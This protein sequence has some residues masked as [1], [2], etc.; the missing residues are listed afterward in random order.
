MKRFK[1]LVLGFWKWTKA[2]AMPFL[3]GCFAT[4][5]ATIGFI[6]GKRSE[7][8]DGKTQGKENLGFSFEKIEEE[9]DR[10]YERK[11]NLIN[12]RP[13]AAVCQSYGAASDAIAEGIGRFRKRTQYLLSER[14][15]GNGTGN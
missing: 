1:A 4:L 7:K 10:E 11:K 13:A 15:V 9:C 2:V 6:L 12:S 5:C 3:A 14:G 8:K